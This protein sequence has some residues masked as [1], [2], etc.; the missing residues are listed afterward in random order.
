MRGSHD[1]AKIRRTMR[2]G[3]P[4]RCASDHGIARPGARR[5]RASTSARR[6]PTVVGAS[7]PRRRPARCE[8]AA[9]SR[10]HDAICC[11]HPRVVAGQPQGLWRSRGQR[12]AHAGSGLRARL[13]RRAQLAAA[14]DR[15]QLRLC[16][17]HC[18]RSESPAPAENASSPASIG[19]FLGEQRPAKATASAVPTAWAAPISCAEIWQ[20]RSQ[21]SDLL[22]HCAVCHAHARRLYVGCVPMPSCSGWG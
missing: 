21:R 6:S 17:V 16:G 1:R 7:A 2:L 20:R 4:S 13:L 18:T 8:I 9:A 11:G 14:R 15:W 10:P 12:R 19:L 5:S 22:R 3:M